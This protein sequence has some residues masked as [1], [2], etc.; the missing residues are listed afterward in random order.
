MSSHEVKE[1]NVMCGGN[2]TSFPIILLTKDI[3]KVQMDGKNIFFKV[4]AKI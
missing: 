1:I 4:S 2:Y 3:Q